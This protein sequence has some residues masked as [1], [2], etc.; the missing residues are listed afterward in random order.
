LPFAP[1]YASGASIPQVRDSRL[2]PYYGVGGWL[3]F[4]I[5][6]I[7]LV[8]PVLHT[9]NVWHAYRH[10]MEIFA[11]SVH[12]YSLYAFYALETIA[13]FALY[14]YGIFAGIQLWRI[15]PNAVQHAKR[16]LLLLLAYRFADYVMGINWIALMASQDARAGAL[17][18]FLVGSAAKNLL[19]TAFYVA[20][21]YAYLSRSERVRVT[22]VENR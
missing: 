11:R 13:G 18:N 16:F 8:A 12:P 3:L 5:F 10:S 2:H 17:S 22:F 1:A 19:R 15:Q 14:G 7:V 4:F 6:G 20:L 9:W 21:W